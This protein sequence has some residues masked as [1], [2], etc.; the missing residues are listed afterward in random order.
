MRRLVLATFLI[1]LL[2]CW[3]S[4]RE[5]VLDNGQIEVRLD[6]ARYGGSISYLSL[7]GLGLNLVNT[8]D[9]GRLIQQ[10]Y[11]LGQDREMPGQHRSW[12]PWPINPI[13]GG[14]VYGTPARVIESESSR[15]MAYV[16]TAPK[17]W[18]LRNVEPP[19]TMEQW[20]LLDGYVVRVLVRFTAGPGAWE[21]VPRHQEMPA[22]YIISWFDELHTYLGNRPWTN[23]RTTKITRKPLANDPNFPWNHWPS[24]LY[25]GQT[26]NWAAVINSGNQLGVGV[27]FPDVELFV[28][29]LHGRTGQLS[30]SASTMYVAPLR[31]LDIRPGEVVE[32]QYELMIGSLQDIRKHAYTRRR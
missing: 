5:I 1:L 11:Y 4:A 19:M 10:S 28:G 23:G 13:Q 16:K 20:V 21:R 14:D 17:L 18:D 24:E 32:Y 26:E 31:T 2:P 25:P 12:R 9:K 15:T 8:S 6:T 27:I 3:L 22:V 29:G 7:S 30:N